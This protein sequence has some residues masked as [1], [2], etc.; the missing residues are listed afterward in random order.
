MEGCGG[1]GK[2]LDWKVGEGGGSGVEHPTQW[3]AE[4]EQGAR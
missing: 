1:V 2:G 3:F 4:G